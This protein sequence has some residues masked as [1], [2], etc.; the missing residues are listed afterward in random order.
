[1]HDELVFE[2]AEEEREEIAQLAKKEME[3]VVSLR[4]P[5][6]VD[7]FFGHNWAEAH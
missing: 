7:L 6:K 2:V 5:L 3:G 4:V 1:V